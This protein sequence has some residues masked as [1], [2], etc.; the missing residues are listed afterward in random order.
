[1]WSQLYNSFQINIQNICHPEVIFWDVWA[2]C[3]EA[4]AELFV[5]ESRGDDFRGHEVHMTFCMN[6][7]R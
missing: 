3:H 5:P 7:W 4:G 1:M 6:R 2:D